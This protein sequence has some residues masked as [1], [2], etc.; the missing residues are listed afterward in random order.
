MS[1]YTKKNISA[2]VDDRIYQAVF[3][4]AK[5]EGKSM[6]KVLESLVVN[7]LGINVPGSCKN[8]GTLNDI[9]SKFCNQCGME[10]L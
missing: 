2:R 6:T 8:C 9:D 5:S 3:E 7:T 4:K 1:C 10:L